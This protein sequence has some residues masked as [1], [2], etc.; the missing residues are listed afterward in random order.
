MKNYLN[1]SKSCLMNTVFTVSLCCPTVDPRPWATAL[2]KALPQA[3]IVIWPEHADLADYAVTWSPTQA[4]FD[5]QPQLK[6]VFALGAGVDALLRLQ[7]PESLQLIRI[8]DGGMGQ[9]M[10][11][12]V[13]HALL[14]HFRQFERYAQDIQHGRWQAYEAVDFAD[15]TVGVMGL[16][17]L[18]SQIAQRVKSLGFQVRGYSRSP[19]QLAGVDCFSGAGLEDFLQPCHALVCALPLTAETR[20]ILNARTL[21]MLQ[22]GA[23]LINVA[24]GA[25]LVESDLLALLDSGQLSGACLDVLREE[26]AAAQH[27]FRRHPQITLTPHI[28]ALTLLQP[29][30][31]QISQKMSA[32]HS[33][34]PISGRVL[35]E[36]GY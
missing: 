19:K 9:Q 1:S 23:Y 14:R 10:A 18:G 26:P 8:E 27:P 33:G 5:A 24:R 35:R 2:A 12:Y 29:S 4:F 34:Q 17:Q 15:L 31:M 7:L 6:A 13:T 28:A 36:R 21:G 25:Q 32:L 11:D 22:R 16:G 20:D 3:R 30:V